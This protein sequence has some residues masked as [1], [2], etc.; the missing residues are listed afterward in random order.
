MNVIEA[1]TIHVYAKPGATIYTAV[2]NSLELAKKY[3]AYVFLKFNGKEIR[4][5]RL[6]KVEQ[7]VTEYLS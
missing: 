6:D 3:N 1:E 4:I 2:E 5:E 7:K